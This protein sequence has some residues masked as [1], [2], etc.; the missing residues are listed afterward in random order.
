MREVFSGTHP[1]SGD[2]A[3]FF[4]TGRAGRE[5]Q[6]AGNRMNGFRFREAFSLEEMQGGQGLMRP[7]LGCEAERQSS[8]LQTRGQPCTA[9]RVAPEQIPP[10]DLIVGR[11]SLDPLLASR[12][13]T[14]AFRHG[15]L[16][17]LRSSF[18]PLL[19]LEAR[20]E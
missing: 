10:I 6:G 3:F 14:T 19:L 16:C 2:C 13:L 18:A 11:A 7:G 15:L 9:K 20:E 12:V 8:D 17:S 4:Q 1:R 5:V